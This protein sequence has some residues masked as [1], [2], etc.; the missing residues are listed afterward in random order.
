MPQTTGGV[1]P[2]LMIGEA[3]SAG[4]AT[5]GR[6]GPL[7]VADRVDYPPALGTSP[8]NPIS[9]SQ[10]ALSD[11]PERAQVSEMW[12]NPDRGRWPKQM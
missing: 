9:R 1:L 7:S 12:R 5:D 3:W 8:I 4:A 2:R 10:E 6:D 11:V